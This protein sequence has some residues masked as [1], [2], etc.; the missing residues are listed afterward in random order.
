MSVFGRTRQRLWAV[1]RRKRFEAGMAEELRHHVEQYASDLMAEGLPREQAERRARLE[2]GSL[3]A[4]KE[5]CRDSRGLRLFDELR[6]T[7]AQ[8]ARLIRK[9]PG[10]TAASMA[11]IGL[12]LGA[13]LAI[14]AVVDAIML[15]PLPFPDSDRLMVLYKT[16]PGVGVDRDGASAANLYERRER[17]GSLDAFAS[18]ALLRYGSAIVGEAGSTR[19]EEITRVS[20]GFFSVLGISPAKGREFSEQEMTY[21]TDDVAILTDT[22]WRQRFG[23]DPDVIGNAIRINGAPR[24]VVGVLPAGFRFLSSESGIYLPLSSSLEE[25]GPGNRHSGQGGELIARLQPGRSVEEAQAQIDALDASIADQYRQ[26]TLMAEAGYRTVVTSLHGDHI[27]SVRSTILL[28]QGGVAFLLL[29]GGANLV[30]LLLMRASGRS[31]EFAVR[32]ALGASRPRVVA[33]VMVETLTLTTLGAFTGLA[34]GTAGI[35]LLRALGADRLPLGARVAF[36]GHLGVA[37]LLVSIGMGIAAGV[38]IAW[39]HLR[40]GGNPALPWGAR[41]GTAGLAAQR[42]RHGFIVV[43]LALAFVLLSG[44][45]SLGLSLRNAASARP[46]FQPEQ[47]LSGQVSLPGSHYSNNRTRLSF[48]ARVLQDLGRLPGVVAA[49]AAT[50]VPLSGQN[51]KS[52]IGVKDHPLRPG[53]LPRVVYANSVDGDYFQAMGIRLI[54]GRFVEAA[55]SRRAERVCVVDENVA[56]YYW[57]EGGAIGHR[58]FQGPRAES[59]AD[60]YTIVGVV[61]AVKQ[62]SL[63]EG[64]THG[65]VYFPFG[66]RPNGSMYLVARTIVPPE[67]LRADLQRIV[68]AADPELPVYDVRPMEARVGDSLLARRAPALLALLFAATALMLAAAGTYG[69]LSYAVAQ[70]RREIGVRMALGAGAGAIRAQ[71]VVMGL[72]LLAVAMLLGAAGASLAGWAMRNQLFGVPVIHVPTLAAAGGALLLL[73]L[74]ACLFPSHRAALVSPVEALAED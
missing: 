16:Y 6:R 59:D 3:E 41:G 62:A 74:A 19:R 21:E 13:N 72:R 56:R 65:A 73:S 42:L 35:H 9:A 50:N 7:L 2:F 61:G 39:F 47:V 22:T 43:Q 5:E 54:E 34:A 24:L 26:P 14:F 31:K 30:N 15:R 38:P 63:T 70:R 8:M 46:G 10:L 37:A 60:L 11:V 69:I 57:P 44:A 53:E 40:G 51:V 23:A 58:L 55:D 68:R 52:G 28:V 27:A 29:I 36:D 17:S 1:V 12:C 32:M 33:D 71:F 67:S 64:A 4:V 66:H 25:R 20:S 49:G 48:V 18:F 45:G